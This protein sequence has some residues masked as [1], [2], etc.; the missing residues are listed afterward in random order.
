MTKDEPVFPY[1]SDRGERL[2][3][4]KAKRDA[5]DTEIKL[6]EKGIEKAAYDAC[7]CEQHI[8]SNEIRVAEGKRQL[9]AGEYSSG[10]FEEPS[11]DEG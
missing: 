1:T 3:Y 4:L 11:H 2:A 7:I 10:V 5:I 8:R 9:T 6:I